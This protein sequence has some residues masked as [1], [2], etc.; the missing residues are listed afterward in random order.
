MHTYSHVRGEPTAHALEVARFLAS[1][2]GHRDRSGC[3]LD[4][5]LV[6][7]RLRLV[8]KALGGYDAGVIVAAAPACARTP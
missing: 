2:L 1:H 5:G 8:E 3:L 4:G 6:V 7:R